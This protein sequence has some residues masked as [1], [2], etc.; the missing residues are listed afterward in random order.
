MSNPHN[1]DNLFLQEKNSINIDSIIFNDRTKNLYDCFSKNN[2]G[3]IFPRDFNSNRKNQQNACIPIN[4]CNGNNQINLQNN[5]LNHIPNSRYISNNENSFIMK[6]VSQQNMKYYMTNQRYENPQKNNYNQNNGGSIGNQCKR[7]DE[8]FLKNQS[9]RLKSKEGNSDNLDGST[10]KMLYENYP[11]YGKGEDKESSENFTEIMANKYIFNKN[12]ATNKNINKN[13]DTLDGLTDSKLDK[14]YF[15]DGNNQSEKFDDFTGNALNDYLG[16]NINNINGNTPN[17][18][19]YNKLAYTCKNQK[20]NY[21]NVSNG[22]SNQLYN[23]INLNGNINNNIN[24][25][26]RNNRNSSLNGINGVKTEE[27]YK[28]DD[29]YKQRNR[30]S[31]RNPINESFA[32]TFFMNG[33]NKILNSQLSGDQIIFKN[34]LNRNNI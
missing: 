9:R 16:P 17:N 8:D 6:N 13:Y 33:N 2:N 12:K 18:N 25:Y 1:K 3:A 24:Y 5:K 34:F 23:N 15:I 4:I 7:T 32:R 26:S 22:N 14:E 27:N 21:N 19:Y 20:N 30:S 31:G 29:V 11:K 28:K 10:D